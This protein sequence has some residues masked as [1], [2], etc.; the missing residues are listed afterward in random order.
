MCFCIGFVSNDTGSN[1][2]VQGAIEL[3]GLFQMPQGIMRQW[4][5]TGF[6][7]PKGNNF[8]LSYL[9]CSFL[10]QNRM[11][12]VQPQVSEVVKINNVITKFINLKEVQQEFE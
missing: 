10:C 2:F 11:K 5:L 12:Y 6:N 9:L 3:T 4:H 1:H 8:S 7:I